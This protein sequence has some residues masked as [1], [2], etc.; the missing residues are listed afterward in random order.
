MEREKLE[1]QIDDLASKVAWFREN[2][3]LLT[4]QEQ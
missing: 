2:Q 1:G 4:D 3:K